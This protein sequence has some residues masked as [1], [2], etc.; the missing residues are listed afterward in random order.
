MTGFLKRYA[1]PALAILSVTATSGAV[2]ALDFA[3]ATFKTV[4]VAPG[5]HMLSG[6]GGNIAVSSGPDGVFLV[7]DEFARMSVKLR[8]AVRAISNRPIRFV[9]NTHWHID[10][11]GGNEALGGTGTVII[12]HDNVRRLMA[13]DQM[14]SVFGMKIPAS[15]KAALPVVTF[16]D[17]A[18]FH[19]NG[20]TIHIRHVPPAHTDGDSF[21]HFQMADVIHT[22][23]LYFNNL[24][25]FIDVEHGGSIDGMIAAADIMLGVAGPATKIIPGHGP[26]SDKAGLQ[27]YRD[28]L[29]LIRDRIRALMAAGRTLDQILAANPTGEFDATWGKG[30][31]KPPLLVRIVHSGMKAR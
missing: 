10:H 23:D 24:Y 22:G 26:L 30:F 28:V 21:V 19:L 18:T 4:K 9:L 3:K 11:S 31:I 20:E 2:Q 14:I 8:A 29:V 16:S 15:P 13:A 17:T 6:V 12:A 7:D 25:P 1:L 5:L 27:S